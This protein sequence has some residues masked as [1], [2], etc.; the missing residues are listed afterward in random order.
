MI[1]Q[2]EIQ[3]IEDSWDYILMNTQ[4]AGMLFY[5]DLFGKHPELRPLFRTDLR[6]QARKLVALITFSVNKLNDFDSVV[7][8]I[9]AL[10]LRHNSYGVKPEHYEM[11]GESLMQMLE[12]GMGEKW[13]ID[14]A[15][16]WEK[17]YKYLSEVMINASYN[18]LAVKKTN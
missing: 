4:E 7:S 13:N 15:Y 8:D 1:Q 12:K 14:L 10:G 5:D 9:E 2:K 6:D 18:H 16:A 17:L 11:V 3:L